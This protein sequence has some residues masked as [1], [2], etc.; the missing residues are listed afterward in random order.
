MVGGQQ[1]PGLAGVFGGKDQQRRLL[2]RFG[3]VFEFEM[4][5]LELPELCPVGPVDGPAA[6]DVGTTVVDGLSPVRDIQQLL[7]DVDTGLVCP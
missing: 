4:A 1:L 3:H 2:E 6:V 5:P 7:A